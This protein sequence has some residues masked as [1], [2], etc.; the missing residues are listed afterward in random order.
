MTLVADSKGKLT[1][2]F[3]IPAGVPSGVKRV[4]FTGVG[5]STGSASFVGEGTITTNTL[6]N[7]TTVTSQRF[8]PP[9][10][11]IWVGRDPLAQTFTLS[12]IRQVSGVEVFIAA[13]GTTPIVCQLR[14]TSVGYPTQTIIAEARL[15]AEDVRAGQ[16]NRFVFRSPMTLPS[17]QEYAFVILTD[18]PD[19]AAGIAELGKF[20]STRQQWVTAQPYS[21]GVLLS[22]S[23]ASTWT[24]H[25]DRDLTFR[26]LTAKYTEAES[27]ISLGTVALTNIT[28]LMLLAATDSPAATVQAEYELVLPDGTIIPVSDGQPIRLASKTTGNTTVR[29]R[30]KAD[31]SLASKLFPGTQLAAGE[32]TESANYVTRA[33]TGGS[34]VKVRVVYDAVIP[35]GSAVSAQVQAVGALTWTTVPSDSSVQIN[36]TTREYTHIISGLNAPNLR[37]QLTL[38]GTPT[39]RPRVRNLRVIVV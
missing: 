8:D 21:V 2:S 35:A 14:E 34:S 11:V 3:L 25:Q 31:Q 24:A 29:A 28:D 6:R 20:D 5:G 26:L 27:T 9:P 36:E 13:K 1:G 37:V 38:Q 17:G 23:N 16:F 30:L 39:A 12:E 18:S 33:M 32:V 19:Y 4:Q 10:P 15:N 22:S 7:V